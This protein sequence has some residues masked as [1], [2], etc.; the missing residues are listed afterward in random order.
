MCVTTARVLG[1]A[2]MRLNVATSFQFSCLG[3]ET[4]PNLLIMQ[5]LTEEK[6]ASDTILP[7]VTY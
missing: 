6:G 4:W 3:H 7:S 5:D 2:S 1:R